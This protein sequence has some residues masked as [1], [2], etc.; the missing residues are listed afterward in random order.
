MQD[1]EIIKQ[2]IND[3]QIRQEMMVKGLEQIIPAKKNDFDYLRA[4]LNLLEREKQTEVF[5]NKQLQDVISGE[6]EK[7]EK[8]RETLGLNKVK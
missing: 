1:I 6:Y 3:C 4:C 7:K 8:A 2:Q 5:L